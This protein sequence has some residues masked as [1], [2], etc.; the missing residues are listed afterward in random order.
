MCCGFFMQKNKSEQKKLFVRG[1]VVAAALLT[2]GVIVSMGKTGQEPE[3]DGKVP[4]GE[5]P[6][7]WYGEKETLLLLQ[8]N[9]V[10]A[11]G[12]QEETAD[13]YRWL[14]AGE[15]GSVARPDGE[16]ANGN[17]VGEV[18]EKQEEKV[19]YLTFDDGPSRNTEKIL[20]ILAEYDAKATFFLIGENL[21]EYGLEIAKRAVEEG[22]LL[23]MH[24]ETH[25]YDKIYCSVDA[26][27][28]DYDK[29]AKRFA[30]EFGECP[31]YFRFPGGSSSKY[32]NSIRDRLQEELATRGFK[33][34]DWNVSGEDSVGTP[35]AASIKKNIFGR[36]YSVEAPIV[37]LHDSPCNQLTAE[38]LPQILERLSEEGYQ[39]RTLEERKP[40][41]FP[42]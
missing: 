9:G 30:E 2:A 21:T 11:V 16:E 20:D 40:Y 41:Q 37:L 7:E 34:Y 18:Q 26:F 12:S 42:R 24:T 19:I 27:L 39:F 38:V 1:G 32:I 4:V 29:L 5:M 8:N 23:G 33:G 28:Q 13:P 22:H 31:A 6:M 36:I 25:R 3:H 35:T 17:P 10:L 14:H 15:K